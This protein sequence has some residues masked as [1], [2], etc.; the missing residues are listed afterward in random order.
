MTGGDDDDGDRAGRP[1]RLDEVASLGCER[2]IH[3]PLSEL[4]F[5]KQH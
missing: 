2:T 3:V 1:W 4:G 5:S